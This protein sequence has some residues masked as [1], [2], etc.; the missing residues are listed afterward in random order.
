MTQNGQ[1]KNRETT[2]SN[3]KMSSQQANHKQTARTKNARWK[4][5]ER[6]SFGLNNQHGDDDRTDRCYERRTT[7]KRTEIKQRSSRERIKHKIRLWHEWIG[8]VWSNWK[9]LHDIIVIFLHSTIHDITSE[10]GFR[11]VTHSKDCTDICKYDPFVCERGT[12]V[13]LDHNVLLGHFFN[14]FHLIGKKV[15]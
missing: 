2:Y 12:L 7:K 3:Q 11:Y 6:K 10:G 8:R 13:S 1:W 9:F 5:K 4:H 15:S 14:Q